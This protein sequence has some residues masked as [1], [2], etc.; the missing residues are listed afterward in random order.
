V[1]A[2]AGRVPQRVGPVHAADAGPNKRHELALTLRPVHYPFWSQGHLNSVV[3][4]DLLARSAAAM[5]PATI[6]VADRADTTDAG[7]VKDAFTGAVKVASG[8]ALLA[9]LERW[10]GVELGGVADGVLNSRHV[11]HASESKLDCATWVA[12]PCRRSATRLA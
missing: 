6:S 5:A 3:R 9:P 2:L 12:R 7:T 11:A 8:A 4:V 10:L 1:Q